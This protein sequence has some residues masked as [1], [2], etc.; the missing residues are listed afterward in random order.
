MVWLRQ[1]LSRHRRY[2]E[3]SESIR[4]HLDEKIADLIDRGLT[5]EEAERTARREFGNATLI[6]ERSREVW[7]WSTMENLF[8]DTRYALRGLWAAPVYAA[9]VMLT[10]ALGL[11]AATT[12]LAIVDSVMFRPVDLPHP[13]QLVTLSFTN[14]TG[15]DRLFTRAQLDSFGRSVPAF[16]GVL[17]Y[18]AIPNPVTTPNGIAMSSVMKTSAN[19]FQLIGVPAHIGRTFRDEDSKA[20]VAVVSNAFWRESLHSDSKVLGTKLTVYGRIVTII[21]VMPDRF[22]F[23]PSTLD[24]PTVAVPFEIDVTDFPDVFS[25]ARLRDGVAVRQ[26]ERQLQAVFAHDG[27]NAGDRVSVRSYRATVISDEQPAL[28]ALLSASLILLLIAC[29][30]AA[31]L[32]I[33]RGTSQAG[34]MSLRS[35]LGASRLR[36]LQQVV[37]ESVTT[38]LLGA[39]GGLVFAWGVVRWARDMYAHQ[40]PR[41]NEL[42]VHPAVFVECTVLA[43]L[44]GLLAALAPS[45]N[46][47]RSTNRNRASQ[48]TRTASRMR[49]SGILVVAEVALACVLL[50]TTGL[51]LRTFR[52]L[53]ETPLGFDPHNVTAVVLMNTDPTIGGRAARQV[54]DGILDGLITLPGIEAGATQTSIP[55]SSFNMVV[56]PVGISGTAVPNNA[57]ALIS[58]ISDGYSSTMHTPMLEGRS[59]QSTDHEG[60][61]GVCIVNQSFARRFLGGQQSLGR[62][63]EFPRDD[64]KSPDD[65]FIK[66]PLTVIGVAADEIAGTAIGTVSPTVFV[67]YDQFPTDSEVAGFILGLAPQFAVRSTLPRATLEREIRTVL[68]QKAHGMAVMSITPMED[69]MQKSLSERR[70]AVRLASYFGVTALLLAAVGLYGVLSYT[71]TQRQ[72]EIG[73]RMALGSSRLRVVHL[74]LWQAGI[75]ITGGLLLG[76]LGAWPAGHVIGAFLF[77]VR[78]LDMLNLLATAGLLLVVCVV[79]AALP[80]WRAAQVDPMEA[81]RTE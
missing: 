4:E 1:L 76:L 81:L 17:N 30:N 34:R 67:N 73:I 29:A 79:A 52:A 70:L 14:A 80:S 13:Q 56:G 69:S 45:I 58:L 51:L 59:F 46:M 57:S 50:V 44:T 25:I 55:F 40:Y 60:T 41:F 63:L 78:P 20:N 72:R 3:L 18:T 7:Q 15:E 35:A 33:V 42:A 38:S 10:L 62:I 28:I 64:P 24:A 65:R 19:F 68:K 23:P 36:L 48:A 8:T 2:D 74:V 12:M 31:N 16:A 43:I 77:G 53:E 27:A 22:F 9:T 71:V 5:R 75:M 49:L 32:Q 66:Q 39:M 54:T 11:G 21:G 37:T 47:L 6:E 61:L 26:A